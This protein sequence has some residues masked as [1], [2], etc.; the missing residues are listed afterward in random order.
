MAISQQPV[1]YVSD[2]LGITSD[3]LSRTG[4]NS[5]KKVVDAAEHTGSTALS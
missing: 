5:R 1:Q 2:L 4:R 3:H